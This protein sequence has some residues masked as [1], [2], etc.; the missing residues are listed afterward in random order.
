MRKTTTIG[1]YPLK[2]KIHLFKF[3]GRWRMSTLMRSE[4]D[5]Q[6]SMKAIEFCSRVNKKDDCIIH[7]VL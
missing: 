2:N 4:I 5:P 7:G 6:H 3:K 1:N